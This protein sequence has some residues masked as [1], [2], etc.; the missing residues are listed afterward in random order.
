MD[1]ISRHEQLL[2]V[3]HLIDILFGARQPLTTAELKERLQST[4]RDRRDVG[5]EH[6]PRHRVPGAV[7]LRHEG[8]EE[9][10]AQRDRRAG[11]VDPAGPRRRGTHGA[12]DLASRTPLARRGP[13]VSRAAGRHGLL[14]G[15]RAGD[16]ETGAGRHAASCSPTSPSTRRGSS[17]IPGRPAAKYRSRTLNSV[18]RAIRNALE[19]E[20]RYTGLADDAAAEVD[21]PSRSARPLRRRRLHRRLPC[22]RF[23]RRRLGPP[24]DGGRRDDPLLQARPRRR[25]PR[26]LAHL[27]AI[28]HGGGRSARRQHHD[29]PLDRGRRGG[30]ASASTPS[31][32]GGPSRSRFIRG[33]RSRSRPTAAWCSTSRG[34]GTARCC[35]R[36]S[37]SARW[38]RC[39]SRSTSATGSPRRRPPSPPVTRAARALGGVAAGERLTGERVTRGRRSRVSPARRSS[40]AGVSCSQ[41]NRHV[42]LP[43][44]RPGTFIRASAPR[45]STSCSG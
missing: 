28:G 37:R 2:R 26:H 21:D 32:R 14:A 20:I 1:S 18:H 22:R 8:V 9:A 38:P 29:L 12:A 5:Q 15:H 45:P 42:Q 16:R 24:P 10:V 23:A 44:S 13:G 19:L 30:T 31:G 27:R 33:R 39:S 36:S 3:F 11:L 41:R 6:P 25:R 17:S 4:G 7:R 40:I 34:P 43:P 35:R